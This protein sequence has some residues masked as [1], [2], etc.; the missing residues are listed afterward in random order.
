[1]SININEEESI[2]YSIIQDYVKS[3]KPVEINKIIPYISTITSKRSLNLNNK[4]IKQIIKQLIKKKLIVE[5]SRL[6]KD[7]LMDNDRR[8]IIYEYI[9][10]NPAVYPHQIISKLEIPNHIVVWHLNVLLDFNLI[11]KLRVDNHDTFYESSLSPYEA[12]ISYYIRH[13]K[14]KKIINHLRTN[15]EGIS[16]TQMSKELGIHPSTIRKYIN[17]LELIQLVYK[18]HRSNKILYYLHKDYF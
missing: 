18:K 15:N 11:K 17:K 2:V 16:K 4:G 3:K 10:E 5:G 13:K 7:E 12:K 8:R 14:C 9:C 6:T 1:M